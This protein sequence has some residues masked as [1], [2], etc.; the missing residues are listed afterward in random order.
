L[1]GAPLTRGLTGLVAATAVLLAGLLVLAVVLAATA[2]SRRRRGTSGVLRTLGLG[3]GQARAVTLLELLPG[4]LATVLP[5]LAVGV[6]VA[7]AV[8]GPLGLARLTGQAAP[9][10]TV[11]PWQLVLLVL[12]A[13]LA[14]GGLVVAEARARRRVPLAQVLRE[15]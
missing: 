7:A 8:T 12:P 9:P 11:V 6:A 15:G 1:R 13:V 5:G 2:G 10:V 14:V 3:E 4:V